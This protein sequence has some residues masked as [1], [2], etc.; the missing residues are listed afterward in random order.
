MNAHENGAGHGVDQL[1]PVF[2]IRGLLLSN[3]VSLGVDRRVGGSN[4]LRLD[5][6]Q[7]QH[8]LQAQGNGQIDGALQHAL[9]G[10]GAAVLSAV[11]RVHNHHRPLRRFRGGRGSQVEPHRL[12]HK[13]VHRRQKQHGAK[14]YGMLF[15][16]RPHL[17]K[18]ICAPT[19]G[20]SVL[21]IINASSLRRK[22]W[23]FLPVEMHRYSR[24]CIR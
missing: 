11:S 9:V 13:K 8:L 23:R 21:S 19:G 22:P 1:D 20:L 24:R 16:H 5:A 15:F 4:H 7:R 10:G 3:G 12:K 18:R 6:A 14:A 2:E 17:Q